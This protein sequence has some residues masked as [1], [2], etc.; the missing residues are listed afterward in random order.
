MIMKKLLTAISLVMLVLFAV[1]CAG[2]V[3]PETPAESPAAETPEETPVETPAETP[4]VEP[5]TLTIDEL[6]PFTANVE[7]IYEGEGNEFAALTEYV[8]FLEGNRIQ[9]RRSNGGTEIV[10]VLEKTADQL[11]EVFQQAETYYKENFLKK[12][13][14]N[15]KI[16]LKAPIAVGTTWSSSTGE[17]STI[18]ALEKELNL[19]YGTVKAVEVTTVSAQGTTK[20][21]FAKDLGLV[22]ILTTGEGYEV[23]SSLKEI[24]LNQ[25]RVKVVNF[26]YPNAKD[27]KIFLYRKN[28]T[29]Q[30]NDIPRNLLVAAY[31]ELPAEAVGVLTANTKVNSLYLNNDGMV[32]V[33]LSQDFLTEMN[34]GS[35]FE[36][37][38]LQSL[39]NTFGDYYGRDKVILTIDGKTYESGHIILDKFEP[40]QV[41]YDSIV[42]M[43]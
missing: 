25:P 34:L 1:S 17:T 7:R 26:Y 5:K 39:A 38:V 2:K 9:I 11:V 43:N 4:E 23:S 16:W 22:K 8:D 29:F 33:D 14:A 28:I 35:G 20:T 32:Y 15:P 36:A 12:D 27:E 24:N 37:L 41:N 42:D 13:A 19:P 30:T 10:Y 18:T 6:Y 40:L 21:Y 3:T 31:K